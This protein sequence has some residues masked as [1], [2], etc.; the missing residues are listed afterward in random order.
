M[1]FSNFDTQIQIEETEYEPTATDLAELDVW[2]DE[3]ETDMSELE[4]YDM[5]SQESEDEWHDEVNAML[6]A[7]GDIW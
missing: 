7:D 4:D 5:R 6:N 1:T 2:L 3:V